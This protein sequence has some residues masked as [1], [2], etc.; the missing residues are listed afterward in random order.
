M[1]TI[2]ID[3]Q[4]T[5][6][7]ATYLESLNTD[8]SDSANRLDTVINRVATLTLAAGIAAGIAHTIAAIATTL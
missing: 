4:Y 6:E 7:I 2:I 5:A 8:S 3:P 1:P